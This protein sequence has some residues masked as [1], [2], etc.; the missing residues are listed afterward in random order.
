VPRPGGRDRRRRATIRLLGIL[1]TAALGVAGWQVLGSTSSSGSGSATTGVVGDVLTKTAAIGSPIS[2][3]SSDAVLVGRTSGVRLLSY[4]FVQHYGSGRDIRS[5]P[6]GR[7][8][9]AFTATPVD[10]DDGK[11]P[12]DLSIRVGD[13]ER[14]PLVVTAD[15][16]VAAVPDQ[17]TNVDL[18]LTDSGLKQSLSLLTGKP[19]T[20][21]PAVCARVNRSAQVGVT[22]D[23]TVKVRQ[24]AVAAGMTSGTFTVSTV[25]LS[26]WGQDGSHPTTPEMAFLHVEALVKLAGDRK[27]YGAE[28][29][30]LSLSIPGYPTLYAR[31]AAA[32]VSTHVDDVIEVPAD[33]TIGTIHYSGTITTASGT[34]SVVTAESVP[35]RIPAD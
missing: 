31:N 24:G 17:A 21:N 23:V 3:A 30:L 28:S 32:D 12:P 16:V 11:A 6:P 27:G 26:Y 4:G 18:V 29:G 15:Y 9:L 22:K 20:Q 13:T 33:L 10:G 2:A 7:R 34:I 14:G 19:S 1:V 35:F 25:S 5:A 8:L